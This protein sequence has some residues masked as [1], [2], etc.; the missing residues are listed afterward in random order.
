M[1][2][3]YIKLGKGKREPFDF[4][5]SSKISLRVKKLIQDCSISY[6]CQN[7]VFCIESTGSRSHA[8]ARLWGLPRIWQEI[9]GV[10]P[11]YILEVTHRFFKLREKEQDRVLLHEIAHIPKNF[12]GA[13]VS[14]NGIGKRI[15][16][17]IN[18]KGETN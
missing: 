4:S 17:F 3:K 10:A 18:A 12:S 7:R 5:R 8:Y 6:I 9:L 11:A 16:R 13:L 15:K 1:A 2:Q 14:H